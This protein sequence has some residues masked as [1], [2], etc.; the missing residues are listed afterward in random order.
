MKKLP[1]GIK[2]L[3]DIL[4]GGYIYI[5]KTGLVH[6]LIE[7][8]KHYFL[9]RPRRFGKSLLLDTLTEIF[10]GHK[11]LFTNC[12]ISQTDYAWTPHPVVSISLRNIPC[13]TTEAFAAGLIRALQRMAQAHAI[14]VETPTPQEGLAAL[15]SHLYA[16]HNQQVVILIDEYDKPII[17]NL[18]SPDIANANQ[19][20]L[21]G[22]LGTLKDL[23]SYLAFTLTTGVTKF[24]QASLFTEPNNV[25]DITMDPTYATLLG[26]TEAE[27]THTLDAHIQAVAEHRGMSVSDVLAE[28]QAWYSGYRFS[29]KAVHVYNPFSVLKYLKAQKPQS[30]WYTKGNPAFLI[31]KV[32]E[33][34]AAVTALA[35]C[36][37]S[38]STLM[39]INSIQDITLLTLMLQMG[40]LTIQDSTWDP[41]LGEMVHTLDFPNKEVHKTFLYS[42]LRDLGKIRPQEIIKGAEQ[43]RKNLNDL[44]P[45]RFVETVN[46]YFDKISYMTVF[47]EHKEGF[48]QAILMLCLELSG[49][50]TQ[51]E[52]HTSLDRIDLIV[53]QPAY[54]L[55]FEL[56]KV[57][58]P[59]FV[60]L[61]QM[62]TKRYQERY[63][64]E[65]KEILVI[66]ISC[67]SISRRIS[68]WESSMYTAKGEFMGRLCD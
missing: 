6:Q 45:A 4:A 22:F 19:D 30:H 39:D 56:L 58:T 53:Q 47:D 25:R 52:M 1:I 40:Y 62:E 41:E 7:H 26:Y 20:L 43:L 59:T 42:F 63:L 37:L 60:A 5:D 31:H 38:A 66:S 55:I 24:S 10:K 44:S 34:P 33:A 14:T 35:G 17:S 57:N 15:V 9:A 65:G 27:L 29:E 64:K 54:T 13:R 51:G 18:E 2:K 68:S 16:K 12:A 48:Y 49:L 3:R 8:G 21:R 36:S 67:S 32:Q 46:S 11:A 28:M 61:D 50:K 23:D